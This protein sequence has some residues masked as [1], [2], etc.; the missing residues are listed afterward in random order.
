MP[1][2]SWIKAQGL[3][4]V[5][6]AWIDDGVL[7][8][9][10]VAPQPRGGWDWRVWHTVRGDEYRFGTSTTAGDA[11]E[12]AENAAMELLLEQPRGGPWH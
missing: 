5:A 8:R 4:M 6:A 12:A 3:L 10:V 11:I 9:L 2:L 1:R 7:I